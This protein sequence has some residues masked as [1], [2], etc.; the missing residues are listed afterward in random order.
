[1]YYVYQGR[2]NGDKAR[3]LYQEYIDAS[4]GHCADELQEE[5][6]F[7]VIFRRVDYTNWIQWEYDLRFQKCNNGMI[8]KS[9]WKTAKEMKEELIDFTCYE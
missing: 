1:M 7:T 5:D 9:F 2:L 4:K 8:C 3:E 6:N